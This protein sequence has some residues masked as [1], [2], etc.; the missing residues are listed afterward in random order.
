[1]NRDSLVRHPG[2]LWSAFIVVHVWTMWLGIVVVP[3]VLGDVTGVYRFWVQNAQNG[4]GVVGI[5]TP[6]VYP[7]LA[8][9]PLFIPSITG[10]ANY[11][12]TWLIMISL[13]DAIAFFYLIRG[14]TSPAPRARAAWWWLA[15]IVALGPVVLG[16][17]DSVVTPIAIWAMLFVVSRPRVAGFLMA[18]GAWI[19]VWPVA[20]GIAAVVIMRARWRIVVSAVVTSAVVVAAGLVAGAG[21]NLL[22]FISTQSTRGLQIESPAASWFLMAI[23]QGSRAWHVYFDNAMLTYQVSGPGVDA[24]AG[25]MTWIMIGGII[26]AVAVMAFRAREGVRLFPAA[27]LALVSALIAFNKVGSPQYFTWF[28][29]V[30]IAGL[31]INGRHWNSVA[32]LCLVEMALTQLIYPWD[33]D[34]ITNPAM[35]AVLILALR[36]VGEGVLY[37][38]A[39]VMLV[40]GDKSERLKRS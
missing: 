36:N 37:C 23:A 10:L 4:A 19:K 39:M 2:L 7:I 11:T 25:V 34:Q 9:V 33:Y 18:V 3:G 28:I 13:G 8:L 22:S 30:I 32:A 27:T 14:A 6:W 17:L 5:A 29:P 16:R 35:P 24:V 31:V 1:M 20:I 38:W 21:T 15:A 12:L 40:R 26:A